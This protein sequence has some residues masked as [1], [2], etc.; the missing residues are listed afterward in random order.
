MRH[1]AI[2][3]MVAFQLN[4]HG[5]QTIDLSATTRRHPLR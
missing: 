1:V 2:K 4:T 3:H 5:Q